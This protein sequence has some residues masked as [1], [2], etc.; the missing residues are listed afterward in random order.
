[1]PINRFYDPKLEKTSLQGRLEEDEFNHA[2]KSFRLKK[3]DKLEVI[4]GKGVL[5]TACVLEITKKHLTYEITHLE[6]FQPQIAPFVLVLGMPK[7]NRLETIL[8]KVTELGCLEVVL[9][10]AD[11]SEKV[12][13]SKN[14]LD[15]AE[16]ILIAAL[17]QSGRLFMPQVLVKPHLEECFDSD[18]DYF[19]GDLSS[20]DRKLKTSSSLLG[21]VIGPESGFSDKEK[22][23]LKTKAYGVLLSEATLRTDTAAI[24]ATHL[25]AQVF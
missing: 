8:E 22:L 12:D 2:T 1:M 15:R 18:R 7:F 20:Q 11:R 6:L 23:L 3:G 14:Q 13:L 25:M 17:K 24:I 4:N 19:F 10:N 21:F 9:F 16:L 5:A